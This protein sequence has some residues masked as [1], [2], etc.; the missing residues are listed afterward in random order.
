[1]EPLCVG[2]ANAILTGEIRDVYMSLLQLKC[3]CM[4]VCVCVCVHH[5][6]G[7]LTS[8]YP[9]T[10]SSRCFTIQFLL[11]FIGVCVCVCVSVSVSVCFVECVL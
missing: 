4:C 1:M 11:G 7:L 6:S 9:G 8:D 5:P 10:N 2:L 3:V